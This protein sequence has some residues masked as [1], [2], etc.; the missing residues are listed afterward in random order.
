MKDVLRSVISIV[1]TKFAGITIISTIGNNDVLNE[2]LP[3]LGS[4]SQKT[5]FYGEIYEI[6]F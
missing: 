4:D 1:Q 3:V 2:T 5:L 6:W